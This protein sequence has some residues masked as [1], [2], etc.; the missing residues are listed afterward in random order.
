MTGG[1]IMRGRLLSGMLCSFG[2]VATH[3][4]I[5][6]MAE[7]N[8]PAIWKLTKQ[9]KPLTKQRYICLHRYL[10][11]EYKFSFTIELLQN[12]Q[13]NVFLPQTHELWL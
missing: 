10:V 6:G 8:L 1:E 13:E 2:V 3:L 5:S 12:F 9:K 4:H 7:P 11:C